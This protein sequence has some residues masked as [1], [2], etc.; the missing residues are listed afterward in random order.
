MPAPTS[1]KTSRVR[2]SKPAVSGGKAKRGLP[3][4]VTSAGSSP[5]AVNAD[6]FTPPVP[7]RPVTMAEL[8]PAKCIRVRGAREHNLKNIDAQIP[9][10]RLV[11][12]TGLSGSGKSSLA[13][14]TIFA[15]G[16]RK[17]MESLSAYARQFLDQLKKPDVDDIEG[18]PP[19]IAIE[20]RSGVSNPRSTVATTTEIYDYLR[21][22]YARCGSPACW[23]PTK[24]RKDGVVQQRCGRA[25]SATGAT[26][27]I[28]AVMALGSP[29]HRAGSSSATAD[30]RMMIL[31]PVVR[32]Q[33]GFHK[34]VLED[35]QRQGWGR[36]RVAPGGKNAQVLEIRDVLAKGGENPLGLARYE[37]HSI[38]IVIDRIV[39]RPDARQRVAEAVESALKLAD[40]SVTISLE[41]DGQWQD[42]VFSEKFACPDH[43][44]CALE[45]LSPRLFSFNSPHGACAECHGLGLIMEFDEELC[46]PDPSKS[47]AEGAVK[48]WKVPPP[49]GRFFRKRL[50]HFCDR[51]EVSQ[52]LSFSAFSATHKRILL[53]G[54][55]PEDE[56]KYGA[57][58]EGVGPSL[59]GWYEKTESSFMREWLGQYM[60][61]KSCPTCHADRLRIEALHVQLSS[62]H[63]ADVGR[64]ASETIIGRSES[65]IAMG[66]GRTLNIAEL[67]RLTINDAADFIASLQLTSE[68][69]TI[70]EPILRELA[71]RLGFLSS[72]GLEYLSLDRKTGTLSGGEA[73][74]IRLATQ[75]G[76]KLVGACYVLDEPTIGLHQRDN[77]RLINTLR[78]LADIGNTV[79]VVEH[80]EDM[81]RAADHVLDVGPGPGVH[82]G[83]IVAQGT[84]P[85][86]IAANSLTGQYLGGTRSIAVPE[87]RRSLDAKR[88]LTVINPRENNLKGDSVT[89]P[90]G[91]LICVTGVSGSGKSTLVSDILLAAARK[92]V[93]TSRARVG[94]HDKITGFKNVDRVIEVDQSPIGRTPRS[95][96]ATYTG[97]FD[98]IRR[99][100]STTKEAKIR[101]YKPGRFSFNVPGRSGG[102]RCEACE[103]QGLKKIEMHFLPDVFVA[104]EVCSGKRYNRETLEVLYRGKSIADVLALTVEQS[105]AF[106]ENHPRILRFVTCLRDV[107]LGYIELGQPSTQLSGGEAQRVKLATELGKIGGPLP[108]SGRRKAGDEDDEPVVVDDLSAEDAGGEDDLDDAQAEASIRKGSSAPAARTASPGPFPSTAH[109]LYVLDEPTT[110]LHFE[111][112]RRLIEVLNRLADAG[113]TLVVIE[114]NLD[115][116]KC[117]DWL[118]DLGPEGGDKGGRVIAA[119]TPE[120]VMDVSGSYTGRFLKAHLKAQRR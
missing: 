24:V 59:R 35:A 25:I 113:H 79:L 82:G 85:E 117:A 64:A 108:G 57:K 74:R 8:D 95:N 104:C 94:A 78:H 4:E 47:L 31:A 32:A 114:H 6:I 26:Q 72:V 44:E 34:E 106:F 93:G 112:V 103:G 60:Q 15:E 66:P 67:S 46:I 36:V 120:Q 80:D 110:G 62:A 116:I 87:K 102:G 81:V 9:R 37:K 70:A 98:E 92:H 50:R 39:L 10:D 118:I 17:Y 83:R 58:F 97:I 99:I 63:A 30:L 77:A 65:A 3:V 69:R 101:G 71:G 73:Q 86:I 84:V 105:C 7:T 119:G 23:F 42:K 18:L 49:M 20:Q 115:V 111:D 2:S 38:D 96:P 53:K 52:H 90:L 33:K 51:F 55:T 75:V 40:G 107:G 19:T 89:F 54:T 43:P 45:E 29:A 1:T 100:F 13:F 12:I 21:L 16:Q 91:G 41:S 61:E 28:D 109:T 14:D 48:P 88:A 68:Q 56:K 11:V 27:I 22:L 76:S 5:E